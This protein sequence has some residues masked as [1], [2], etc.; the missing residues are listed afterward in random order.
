M[1]CER[2]MSRAIR[3][4][5]RHALSC[6]SLDDVARPGAEL[7][8]VP[9]IALGD[10]EGADY[11]SFP[12]SEPGSVD[13]SCEHGVATCAGQRHDLGHVHRVFIRLGRVADR[14]ARE[15]PYRGPRQFLG[16]SFHQLP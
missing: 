13:L 1:S 9:E 12:E 5:Y 4:G 14:T 10:F 2:S 8:P 16:E 7:T 6:N 11:G 3:Q 15:Q